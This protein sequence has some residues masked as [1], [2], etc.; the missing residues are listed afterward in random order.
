MLSLAEKREFLETKTVF[1]DFIAEISGPNCEVVL[2]DFHDGKSTIIHIVN[3]ELSGRKVGET[4]SGVRLKK[5]MR[6]DW[7][8]RN[9]VSNYLLVNE[10]D[11]KLF[12]ASTLYLKKDGDLAGLLCVNYDLTELMRYRDFFSDKLL[13]GIHEGPAMTGETGDLQEL[14]IVVE[15][16][17][18]RVFLNWDREVPLTQVELDGNPIRELYQMGV[19]N[20]KGAVLRV[21]EL[22]N[23]SPQSIYRY[24]KTIENSLAAVKD[25]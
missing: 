24:T 10:R 1:A 7:H 6:E 16:M 21:S 5:I 3:G 2:R 19:F 22:L 8:N 13:Y 18:E 25:N 15:E 4:I 12:R 14:D 9:A 23:L 11:Q 20:H 17:I